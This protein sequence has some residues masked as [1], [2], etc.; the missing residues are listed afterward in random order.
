MLLRETEETFSRVILSIG[1]VPR[2]EAFC[3]QQPGHGLILF[4][5]AGRNQLHIWVKPQPTD[6]FLQRGAS[7]SLTL[8]GSVN[9]QAQ[10][11]SN[12]R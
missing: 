8:K 10:E 11:K 2:D 1:N 3:L 5:M 6:R 7:Q 12:A 4:P 9:H